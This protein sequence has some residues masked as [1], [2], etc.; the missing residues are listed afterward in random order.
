MFANFFRARNKPTSEKH[1]VKKSFSYCPAHSFLYV[2][3]IRLTETQK[4]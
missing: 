3:I 2:K 4:T 1:K